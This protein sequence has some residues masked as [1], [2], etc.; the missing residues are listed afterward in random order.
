M[1]QTLLQGQIP[2]T[3]TSIFVKPG[4]QGSQEFCPHTPT[5]DPHNNQLQTVTWLWYSSVISVHRNEQ[6]TMKL[7]SSN[8]IL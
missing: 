2:I 1:T 7:K 4:Q 8:L 5:T 3:R 6:S